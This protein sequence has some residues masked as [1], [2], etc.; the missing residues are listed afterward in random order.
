[1]TAPKI[2]P[3]HAYC[4]VGPDGKIDIDLVRRNPASAHSAAGNVHGLP[5]PRMVG[6]GWRV[7]PVRVAPAGE[8][9]AEVSAPIP[10]RPPSKPSSARRPPPDP[11][12][13]PSYHLTD[14]EYLRLAATM[15]GKGRTPVPMLRCGEKRR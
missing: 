15:A 3:T 13:D 14:G 7:I 9:E 11:P 5:W 12:L 6:K 10:P 4:A 1:M 8:V 2:I